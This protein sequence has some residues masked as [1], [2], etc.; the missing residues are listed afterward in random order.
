MVDYEKLISETAS[1]ILMI[2]EDIKYFEHLYLHS[3]N[4]F[5]KYRNMNNDTHYENY[6]FFY[7]IYSDLKYNRRVDLVDTFYRL[8][9]LS[10]KNVNV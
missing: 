9:N 2:E 1:K 10:G 6:R 3:F 8:M 4:L 7:N 5:K